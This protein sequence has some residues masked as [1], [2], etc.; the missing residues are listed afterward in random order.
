MRRFATEGSA[1]AW[2]GAGD[3]GYWRNHERAATPVLIE[4]L[5]KRPPVG[6]VGRCP[7]VPGEVRS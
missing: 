4:T 2:G 5:Q 3:G 6:R 7:A 1:R